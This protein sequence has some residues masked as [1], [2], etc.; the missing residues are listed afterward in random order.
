M[1][2]SEIFISIQGEGRKAGEPTVFVRIAGCNLK[3]VWCDT[4]HAW[5]GGTEMPLEQVVAQVHGA[6]LRS[7]CVTGGEPLLD[8]ETPNLVA[9]LHASGLNVTLMTNGSLLLSSIPACIHKVVDI[10]P[11]SAHKGNHSTLFPPHFDMRNLTYIGEKDDVK[12]VVQDRQDFEWAAAFI[13]RYGLLKKAGNVF[14][15]PA[16]GMLDPALLADW[17]I[18]TRL[19]LRLHLQLHKIVFGPSTNR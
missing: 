1:K 19:P 18:A 17:I 10:K 7:V 2:I 11:P 8:P 13:D 12:F 16:F 4:P 6:E 3:C 5:R 15:G 14:I 9:A